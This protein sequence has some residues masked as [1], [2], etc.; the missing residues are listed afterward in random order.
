[1]KVTSSILEYRHCILL[2]CPLQTPRV[3]FNLMWL[4]PRLLD[5]RHNRKRLPGYSCL[6]ACFH[7]FNPAQILNIQSVVRH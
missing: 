1:M 3:Y 4:R 5:G 2:H 6:E 7:I